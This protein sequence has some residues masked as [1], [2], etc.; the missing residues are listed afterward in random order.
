MY[1]RA[2]RHRYGDELAALLAERPPGWREVA[3]LL[4]GA[5]DAH[6]CVGEVRGRWSAMTSVLRTVAVRTFAAWVVFCVA[7][8]GLVKTTED[9]V[10]TRAAQAHLALGVGYQAV[11]GAFGVAVLAVLAGG[12]PLASCAI[13]TAWRRRDRVVRGLVAVPVLAMAVVAVYPLI[14]LRLHPTGAGPRDPVNVALLV[15]WLVLAGVGGGASLLA[16]RAAVARSEFPAR[17]LRRAGWAAAVAA[18][19]MTAGVLGIAGYGLALHGQESALFNSD[20]GLLATPLP[21]SYLASLLVGLAA[22]ATADRA[23]WRGLRALHPGVP[24]PP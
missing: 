15:G 12:L 4:R 10:F 24:A 14:M 17:L 13:A 20:A 3:D 11:V 5:V 21:L 6:C 1:P 8:I 23:A 9:P 18:A 16:I 19:A 22:V 2:W 7:V